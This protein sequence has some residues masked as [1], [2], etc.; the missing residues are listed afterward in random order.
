MHERLIGN[1][2]PIDRLTPDIL[3]RSGRILRRSKM[4]NAKFQGRLT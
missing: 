4:R 3:I 1:I 2:S